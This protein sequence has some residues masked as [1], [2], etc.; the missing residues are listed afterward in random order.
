LHDLVAVTRLLRQEKQRRGPDVAAT[1]LAPTPEAT[2]AWATEGKA[3]EAAAPAWAKIA[4]S[5]VAVPVS[6]TTRAARAPCHRA[7]VVL[8]VLP[9]AVQ[10]AKVIVQATTLLGCIYRM[11]EHI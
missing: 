6:S 5:M 2:A 4:R 10:A 11:S 8:Q 9:R 7:Q 1:G 3:F